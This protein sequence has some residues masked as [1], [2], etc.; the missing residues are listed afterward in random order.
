MVTERR[1]FER[2]DLES[3]S[4]KI[5]DAKTK[6]EIDFA[7]INVSQQGLAIFTRQKLPE[8]TEVIM[9][10]HPREVRLQVKWCQAKPDDLAIFRSGLEV[11][12]PTVHLDELVKEHLQV[13]P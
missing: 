4:A 13:A 2:L 9:V 7:P 5:Y 3:I 8:G 12:D 6:R 1:R 11:M 10:L